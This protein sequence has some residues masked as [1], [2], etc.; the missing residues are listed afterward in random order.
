MDISKV[1]IKDEM[2][3]TVTLKGLM[4]FCTFLGFILFPIHKSYQETQ[5]KQNSNIEILQDA[6]V[7]YRERI[8]VLEEFKEDIKVFQEKQD[9]NH[10][11]TL[12]AISGLT[13]SIEVL[14]E[15]VKHTK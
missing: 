14:V 1:K 5:E 9:K 15:R 6:K 11:E 3:R 2:N 7:E 10:I 4:A 12:E 13:T 8:I